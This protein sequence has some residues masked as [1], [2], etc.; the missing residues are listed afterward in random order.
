MF[1]R[2]PTRELAA[3]YDDQVSPERHRWIAQHLAACVECRAELEQI[4]FAAHLVEKLPRSTAPESLY[5]S[6]EEALSVASPLRAGRRGWPQAAALAL[7]GLALVVFAWY[8]VFR[9]PLQLAAATSRPSALESYAVAEHAKRMAGKADWQLKT[10]DGRRL[11]EWL[12]TR[13]GLFA[14]LPNKRPEEDAGHFVLSGSKLLLADGF[15]AAVIG[16]EIDGQPVTLL[17]AQLS[18][19]SDAPA[20]ARFSKNV[21]YR[22]EPERGFRVLTW[23]TEGQ[24]YVMVSSLP[25]FGQQ[26]CF[27]CHTT[28]ARRELISRMNPP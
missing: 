28:R 21:L 25:G 22:S 24:A 9:Q 11:Q 6:F 12:M 2:H 7:V 4:V 23:S 19:V 27:L 1:R 5:R 17:T 8:F 20:E 13:S 15:T 26:G 3:Y 18:Q 14:H 10:S 16:Y